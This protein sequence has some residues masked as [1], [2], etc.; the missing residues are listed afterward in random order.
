MP[1]PTPIVVTL[2]AAVMAQGKPITSLTIREPT[3]KDLRLFGYPIGMGEEPKIDTKA[4]SNLLSAV[5]MVPLSTIDQL[6]FGDYNACMTALVSFLGAAPP[7]SSTDGST[8][9]VGGETST[10]SSA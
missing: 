3:G 2:T 8:A 7:T 4:V 5:A 10:T 6:T 1:N 9:P